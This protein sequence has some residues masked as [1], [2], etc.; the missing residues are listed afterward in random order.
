MLTETKSPS[1]RHLRVWSTDNP[2]AA[3]VLSHGLGEHSGRYEEI[4]D[5][6][7][8]HAYSV[9]AMD[10]VGHGNSPGQRGHCDRFADFVGG[11]CEIVDHLKAEAPELPRILIGHSLGGLIV[12]HYLLDHQD[13]VAAAILSGAAFQVAVEVPWWKESAGRLL[14]NLLPTFSMSNE[15]D[16]SA[17]SHD[18]AIIEAYKS[19]PLVHDQVSPRLYTEMTQAMEDALVGAEEIK[20]PLLI[21]AGR[22]DRIVDPAGSIL[23]HRDAASEQKELH[24]FDGMY[25]EIFNEVERKRVYKVVTE[26]LARTLDEAPRTTQ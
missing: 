18:G 20:L 13:D 15:I 8:A 9:Y 2:R 25:H 17:L 10:H 1:G 21:L 14:S 22:E 12:A 11:V 7:N 26:W 23:F 4:A 3:I 24:I 5:H 16:P 19:D 6:L